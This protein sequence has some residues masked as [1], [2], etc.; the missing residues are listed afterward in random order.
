M[1]TRQCGKCGACWIDGQLHW[2]TGK[3]AKEEDLA[4]LVCIAFG[5]EQCINP[6]RENTS[7]DSWAKR[8]ASLELLEL[9]QQVK[10][11]D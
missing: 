6:Q 5:D 3:P 11:N 4:G 10:G 8:M 7:G 1:N 9:E 2:A